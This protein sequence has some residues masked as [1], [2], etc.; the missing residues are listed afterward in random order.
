MPTLVP[1]ASNTAG[2]ALGTLAA[3]LLYS[4]MQGALWVPPIAA[5]IGMTPAGVA[6]LAVLGVGMGVSYLVTHLAEVKNLNDFVANWWPQ[7]QRVYPS[8]KNGEF[9]ASAPI[10]QAGPNTNINQPVLILAEP[11]PDNVAAHTV[12]ATLRP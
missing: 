9:D 2:T 10:A 12:T 7:I 4:Y 8:G 5:A 1:S 6:S 3:G 11:L